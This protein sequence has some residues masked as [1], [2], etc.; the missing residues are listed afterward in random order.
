M[1]HGQLRTEPDSLAAFFECYLP[2]IEA[3]ML[4]VLDAADPGYAGFFG[5]LRYHLGWVDTHFNPC[6]MRAGKRI[7][8]MLCLLC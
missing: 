4:Q 3:E 8:P 7:R 1:M 2:F 5:M 6:R